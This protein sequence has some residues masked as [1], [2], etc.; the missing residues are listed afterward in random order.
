MVLYNFFKNPNKKRK[1]RRYSHNEV[2]H[3]RRIS[4]DPNIPSSRA[5]IY[6]SELDFISRCILDY[7]DI[8]T[9]GELFGFWTQMGTPVVLYAVGPGPNAKHHLTSF[10][11]DC[12]YVDNVEVDLCNITGL[13]HIGQWH[14]HHKL[15]LAHPSG[16][17]V[18]SMMKGVGLH[19]FPRML[20]C[21]GNC[22][23]FSTTINAFN[24]HENT[25]NEYVHAFWDVVDI[26]SPYRSAIESLF[27]GRLYKPHTQKAI[28]GEM[29]LL[30]NKP[31]QQTNIYHQ[32]IYIM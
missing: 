1:D 26:D 25:P 3:S 21:I 10:I 31:F 19:G 4:E 30:S 32:Q 18:A 28:Y 22:T 8:E 14:S 12:E 17:D 24:F 7:P 11:Q 23:A 2:C 5:I 29:K 15:S 16:G 27:A 9:G 20:L 6:Q 13:Q